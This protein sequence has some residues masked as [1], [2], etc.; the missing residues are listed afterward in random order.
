MTMKVVSMSSKASAD[1]FHAAHAVAREMG[2]IGWRKAWPTWEKLGY[3]H[4][5]NPQSWSNWGQKLNTVS[6]SMAAYI[7]ASKPRGLPQTSLH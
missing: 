5:I 6:I 7:A 1:C 4:R 2:V 3:C